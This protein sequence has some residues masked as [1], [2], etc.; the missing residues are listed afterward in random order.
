MNDLFI[1]IYSMTFIA[2]VSIHTGGVKSKIPVITGAKNMIY[3]KDMMI[4]FLNLRRISQQFVWS[5]ARSFCTVI[6]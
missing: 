3:H 4:Q 5:K 6:I 2:L 1:E